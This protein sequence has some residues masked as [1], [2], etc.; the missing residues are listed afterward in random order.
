MV[1]VSCF[2]ESVGVGRLLVDD[3]G[4]WLIGVLS[5]VVGDGGGVWVL[6]VIWDFCF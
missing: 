5:G 6:S 2:F 4:I 3:S 1:G